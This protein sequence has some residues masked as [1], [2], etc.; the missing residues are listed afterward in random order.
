[1]KTYSKFKIFLFAAGIAVGALNSPVHGKSYYVST[2]GNDADSGT[3]V[4]APWATI[5]KVNSSAFNPGD[6]ILFKRG[7]IWR[8]QLNVPSSGSNLAPLTFGA[9]GSGNEGPVI[10]GADTVLHWTALG[11]NFYSKS[12]AGRTLGW[13]LAGAVFMDG[14]PLH[15][16][17]WVTDQATTF[18]GVTVN[19][20]AFNY[21]DS[22]MYL[23]STTSPDAAVVEVA[24][25]DFAIYG[26]NKEYVNF[27]D[28]TLQS[29]ALHGLHF[30]D[31]NHIDAARM[32]IQYCGGGVID[33]TAPMY[34]GNGVE[35][36]QNCTHCSI[37]Q[38]VIRYNFDTGVTPQMYGGAAPEV[39]IQQ[40]IVIQQNIIHD[41]G[42]YGVEIS[43]LNQN[44]LNYTMKNITVA[45]NT[46]YN[47]GKGWSGDRSG[48][49]IGIYVNE[50]AA[51]DSVL[52]EGNTIYGASGSGVL[53]A[54]SRGLT[55]I[56]RNSIYGN[57]KH[58]VMIYDSDSAANN[59]GAKLHYNLIYNNAKLDHPE[60][61]YS[62]FVY[63]VP[64]G[65]GY[66][67]YNNT[68]YD[69]GDESIQNYN[70]VIMESRDFTSP[71]TAGL[72]SGQIKNNIFYSASAVT[73]WFYDTMNPLVEMDY[74]VYYRNAG[75]MIVVPVGVFTKAQFAS[76]QSAA[77]PNEQSSLTDD[78]GL[79]FTDAETGDFSL[80]ENSICINSGTDVGLKE[81]FTGSTVPVGGRVDI[82]AYEYGTSTAKKHTYQANPV[83]HFEICSPPLSSSQTIRYRLSRASFVELSVY[84]L[85]GN[86][87]KHL[88]RQWQAPGPQLITLK[89]N[90]KGGVVLKNGFYLLELKASPGFKTATKIML[91]L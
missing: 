38:S 23:W 60:D 30:K 33:K 41:N 49:N 64:K 75:L 34:A 72:S 7:E 18:G 73:A 56:R 3:S 67:I 61:N 40:D 71:L 62:G 31:V 70:F 14:A 45:G 11:G 81:D 82:G 78:A 88:A 1:M 39:K 25:R 10:S 32:L 35:W 85:E 79:F 86:L 74:N 47:T 5:A 89:E 37:S 65:A 55:T 27:S 8:E 80:N 83:S 28:L 57:S 17:E 63:H 77:A 48:N 50:N 84:S 36:G 15:F 43:I 90:H 42:M 13:S 87:I 51:I 24:V 54:R 66:E 58:G 12:L 19:S 21:T 76:Y 9:Y 44:T 59:T 22:V 16:R 53:I 6:S 91:T 68:F 26:E 4:N 46:I 20:F 52:I 2:S 29:A 69:N